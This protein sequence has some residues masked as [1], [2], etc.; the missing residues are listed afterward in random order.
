MFTWAFLH[1]FQSRFKVYSYLLRG[2]TLVERRR[3]VTRLGCRKSPKSREIE[4]GPRHPATYKFSLSIQRYMDTFF[5][6]G[7]DKAAKGGG[8]TPPV[9]CC[10]QDTVGLCL[11]TALWL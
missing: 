6:S 11:P 8:W 7:K 2:T 9:I 10:A 5:E 1:V 4:L 3:G